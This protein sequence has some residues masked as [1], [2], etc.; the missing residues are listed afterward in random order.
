MTAEK[1]KQTL[2]YFVKYSNIGFQMLAIILAG[3]FGGLK[4]DE[5]LNLNFKYFTVSLTILAVFAALYNALKDL[6]KK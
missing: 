6:L 5:W 3:V 1:E 2:Y 4:L